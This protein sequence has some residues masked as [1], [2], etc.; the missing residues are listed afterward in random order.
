M[1]VSIRYCCRLIVLF[2]RWLFA[3]AL[4]GGY[5]LMAADIRRNVRCVGARYQVVLSELAIGPSQWSSEWGT[6]LR[7]ELFQ[8]HATGI[9]YAVRDQI[10][11]SRERSKADE[12]GCG[13]NMHEYEGCAF[14]VG[15]GFI[16]IFFTNV[17]TVHISSKSMRQVTV[18]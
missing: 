1:G 8:V 12:M 18:R 4:H 5:T 9:D 17:L 15:I 2:L 10:W 7:R 16:I 3:L 6:C 11:S 13:A 14:W